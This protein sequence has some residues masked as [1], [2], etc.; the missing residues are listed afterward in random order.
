MDRVTAKCRNCI[1][2]EYKDVPKRV[3]DG[4]IY[5]PPDGYCNKI[6]PRGY[7]GAGKP[8]GWRC[9]YSPTCFQFE[10]KEEET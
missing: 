4:W 5:F 3:R 10:L 9:G 7:I 2:F 1:Y 8:G 6:F